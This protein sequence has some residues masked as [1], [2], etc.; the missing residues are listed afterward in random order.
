M[1]ER[2]ARLRQRDGTSASS[3]H[4]RDLFQLRRERVAGVALK[5]GTIVPRRINERKAAR[6]LSPGRGQPQRRCQ[7]EKE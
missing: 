2:A 5:S 6:A 4:A 3:H 1:A 7:K